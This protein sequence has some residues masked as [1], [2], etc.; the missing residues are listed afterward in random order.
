ML[1]EGFMEV[2]YKQLWG[3]LENNHAASSK[4]CRR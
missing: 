3:F 1:E 4:R 2:R